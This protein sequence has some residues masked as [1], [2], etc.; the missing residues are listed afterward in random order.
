MIQVIFTD[1]TNDHQTYFIGNELEEENNEIRL[2][3]QKLAYSIHDG[4]NR[5]FELE[6]QTGPNKDWFSYMTVH[7]WNN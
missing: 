1:R 6:E 5:H 7:V 4:I 3:G 2:D